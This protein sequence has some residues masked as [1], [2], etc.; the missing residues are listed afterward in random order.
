MGITN[1]LIL[2]LMR[3]RY[4]E[5][6]TLGILNVFGTQI[7]TLEDPWKDNKVGISCIPTGLWIVKLE[8]SSVNKWMGMNEAYTVQDVPGR[9]QIRVGHPGTDEE[10]THGCIL[11]GLVINIL[12][13]QFECASSRDGC[14]LFYDIMKERHGLKSFCLEII[15]VG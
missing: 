2:R 9:T 12:K 14:S 5:N 1:K 4:T 3:Y 6:E 11:M 7:F 13:G 10:D 8:S 15:D